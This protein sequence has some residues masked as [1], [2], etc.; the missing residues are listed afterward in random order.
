MQIIAASQNIPLTGWEIV[1]I[2][3][4][5]LISFVLWIWSLISIQIWIGNGWVTGI[6]ALLSSI[7]LTGLTNGLA[8]I[9]VA[10]AGLI[11][12]FQRSFGEFLLL[13][14]LHGGRI[15][16][17]MSVISSAIARFYPAFGPTFSA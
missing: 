12:A 17:L 15:A 9:A 14:I 5:M 2:I 6:S 13:L 11:G 3:I 4:F 7:F 8:G 1:G 10:I 16:L